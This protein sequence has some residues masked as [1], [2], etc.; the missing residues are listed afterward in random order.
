MI[1]SIAGAY[2]SGAPFRQRENI[3]AYFGK[4]FKKFFKEK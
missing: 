2:P 1:A 3:V 4:V